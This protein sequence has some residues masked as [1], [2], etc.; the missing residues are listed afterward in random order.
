VSALP[1]VLLGHEEVPSSFPASLQH[2]PASDAIP[3]TELT[4]QL[5]EILDF[6]AF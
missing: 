4:V 6:K 3:A 1:Q 2:V 5:I